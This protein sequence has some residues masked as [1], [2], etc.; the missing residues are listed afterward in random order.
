MVRLLLS[1]VK[2]SLYFSL[3]GIGKATL[4]RVPGNKWEPTAVS[5]VKPIE[6]FTL[7]LYWRAQ[8]RQNTMQQ[9][10][11]ERA[12]NNLWEETKAREASTMAPEDT[13]RMTSSELATDDNAEHTFSRPS[14]N[15][16]TKKRN[17][18]Y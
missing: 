17:I 4:L 7:D 2:F 12:K 6:N 13:D 15:E 3:V 5:C 1:I 14:S 8:L 16:T 18:G 10:S 11:F 9:D